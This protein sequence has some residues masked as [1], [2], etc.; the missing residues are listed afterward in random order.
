MKIKCI[1]TAASGAGCNGPTDLA[2]QCKNVD[3]IN[4]QAI[5]C[6]L[7]GCGAEEGLQ[8]QSAAAAVCAC[9]ESAGSGG[10]DASA[11]A[12][13]VA[14]AGSGGA[15]PGADAVVST[16]TEA[17]TSEATTTETSVPSSSSPPYPTTVSQ[18]GDGQIQVGTATASSIVPSSTS[19]TPFEGAAARVGGSVIAVVAGF[20][21]VVAVL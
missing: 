13:A 1:D 11:G 21:V 17:A 16:S 14:S 4:A 5:N 19:I 2:C 3:K 10:S 18:I 6:V 15:Q 20:A 7:S 8:A 9:V 12:E